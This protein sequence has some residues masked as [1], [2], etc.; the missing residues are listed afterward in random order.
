MRLRYLF[1]ALAFSAA[2]ALAQSPSGVVINEFQYDDTGTDDREFVELYNATGAAVDISG[3]QLRGHDEQFPTDNN[4]DYTVP[5]NTMIP[6]FGFYV[7]GA[8]T[9]ANVNQV[10]GV[11]NLWENDVESLVLVDATGAVQDAVTYE[12]NKITNPAIYP[13][14]FREGAGVYGNF[15]SQDT[16]L[17][18]WGRW[19]DGLDTDDNGRDFGLMPLTPGATNVQPSLLPFVEIFDGLAV[20]ATIPGWRGSFRDPVAT[21]PQFA[22]PVNPSPIPPSPSGGNCMIMWDTTGGG[23]AAFLT[24]GA[25]N[26][27]SLECY[28]Y[29]RESAPTF[30]GTLGALVCPDF[31]TWSIGVRGTPDVFHNHP[32]PNT[33]LPPCGNLTITDT[34]GQTGVCWYYQT[35]IQGNAVI[36][37]LDETTG[38]NTERI[39]ATI[40]IVPGVNDGWQRLRLVISQ[41]VIV[42]NFGGTYGVD[43]SGVR[44]QALLNSADAANLGTAY[45]S[46]R[47]F[48][49]NNTNARPVC[50]DDLI[51]TNTATPYTV[52]MKQ[53]APGALTVENRGLTV[54]FDFFN[55]FSIIP[56]PGGPGTGPF[57]GLCAIDPN[58]ELIPQALNPVGV[59]PFHPYAFTDSYTSPTYNGIVPG[60][61]VDILSLQVANG[62]IVGL[63]Y[64]RHVTL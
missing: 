30:P 39:L 56:C 48:I 37:L 19:N 15:S 60:I 51:V 61:V 21:D 3:W 40:P 57:F 24:T 11:N 64:N 44:V 63:N 2:M 45:M 32:L 17:Q 26:N 55:I 46:Y 7:F 9:V 35:D 22:D 54:G 31:E 28:V 43:N 10:V 13:I 8:A 4:A 5:A 62:L 53:T 49:V 18:A 59:D 42:A 50:V 41:D 38:G 12:A 16:T 52:F 47:E 14:Q 20:G 36:M 33:N 25:T 34:N 23:N 6:A 27:M 58:L 1:G 29:I